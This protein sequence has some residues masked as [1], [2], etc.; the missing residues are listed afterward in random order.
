VRAGL[1]ARECSRILKAQECCLCSIAP[2]ETQRC[3]ILTACSRRLSTFQVSKLLISDLRTFLV[4]WFLHSPVLHSRFSWTSKFLHVAL[5]ESWE[6]FDFLPK[7]SEV[8]IVSKSCAS[9]LEMVVF[10]GRGLPRKSGNPGRSW[11]FIGGGGGGL[12]TREGGEGP[13]GGVPGRR[14][15]RFGSL[16]SCRESGSVGSRVLE[17]TQCSR[18]LSLLDSTQ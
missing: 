13:G 5:R 12:H 8:T 7:H 18:I 2:I 15:W 14:S 9:C 1:W 11:E 6:S 10:E 17:N 3:A 4:L 16:R